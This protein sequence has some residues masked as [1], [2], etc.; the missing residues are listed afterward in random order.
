[1]TKIELFIMAIII[2]VIFYYLITNIRHIKNNTNFLFKPCKKGICYEKLDKC[3]SVNGYTYLDSGS[4]DKKIERK[5][6]KCVLNPRLKIEL[7]IK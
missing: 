6:L 5:T 1:M 3:Y 7:Y 2:I 4:S